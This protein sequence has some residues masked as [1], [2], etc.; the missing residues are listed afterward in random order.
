MGISSILAS[1]K[2]MFDKMPPD[3]VPS[4][5]QLFAKCTWLAL[6]IHVKFL[7][8]LVKYYQVLFDT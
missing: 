6:H 5:S 1:S 7:K 2:N 4:Q 3:R 8:A